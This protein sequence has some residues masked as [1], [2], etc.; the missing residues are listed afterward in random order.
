MFAIDD[1]GLGCEEAS[2]A[3]RQKK[4]DENIEFCKTV[5]FTH[6]GMAFASF[7]CSSEVFH[8]V[9]SRPLWDQRKLRKFKVFDCTGGVAIKGFGF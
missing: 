2:G 1:F 5:A 4:V 8:I 6:N 3:W 9:L 7:A